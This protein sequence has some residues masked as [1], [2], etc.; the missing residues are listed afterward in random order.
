MTLPP[1]CYTRDNAYA[2]VFP[3]EK[4]KYHILWDICENILVFKVF[5]EIPAHNMIFRVDTSD[6]GY[7]V[8]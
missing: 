5:L 4:K 3:I 2:L 8:T 7:F 6:K 1:A